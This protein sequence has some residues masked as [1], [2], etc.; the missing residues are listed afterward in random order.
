MLSTCELNSCVLNRREYTLILI[1]LNNQGCVLCSV[2]IPHVKW[3][4]ILSALR[5][6]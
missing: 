4:S 5:E 3:N 6:F 2:C 1:Q